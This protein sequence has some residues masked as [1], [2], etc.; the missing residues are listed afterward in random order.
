M[1]T[2][3]FSNG[4]T[5]EQEEDVEQLRIDISRL[6]V[7]VAD[8]PPHRSLSLAVTK[9]QEAQHWLADRTWRPA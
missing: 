9:L 8:L 5:T 4:L 6:L 7:R 1:N 2:E 3:T